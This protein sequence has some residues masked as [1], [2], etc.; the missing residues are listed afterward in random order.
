MEQ[1]NKNTFSHTFHVAVSMTKEKT[2][3]QN[4]VVKGSVALPGGTLHA[5]VAEANLLAPGTGIVFESLEVDFQSSRLVSPHVLSGKTVNPSFACNLHCDSFVEPEQTRMKALFD[6]HRPELKDN[7]LHFI[8]TPNTPE[9]TGS[10]NLV[11][12]MKVDEDLAKQMCHIPKY[13]DLDEPLR[14]HEGYTFIPRFI[15]HK[16]GSVAASEAGESGAPLKEF[17]LYSFIRDNLTDITTPSAEG[18]DRNGMPFCHSENVVPSEGGGYEVPTELVT[19]CISAI[20]KSVLPTIVPDIVLD[21]S[22]SV[23]TPVVKTAFDADGFYLIVVLKVNGTLR[24]FAEVEKS[25]CKKPA[26]TKSTKKAEKK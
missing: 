10:K 12:Q 22:T 26:A 3:P 6:A 7:S 13:S 2:P 11:V 23:R 9:P 1:T 24:S 20:R 25:V 21:V 16:E 5:L 15:G 19:S 4:G 18:V 14:S 17:S 8:L